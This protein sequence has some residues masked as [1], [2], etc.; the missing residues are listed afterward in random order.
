[1]IQIFFHYDMDFLRLERMQVDGI[2]NWDVVHNE[3]I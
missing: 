2:L 3:S 1:L